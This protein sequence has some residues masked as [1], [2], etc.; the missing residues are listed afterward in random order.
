ML[1]KLG[2]F[3]SSNGLVK[4]YD[5]E[6]VDCERIYNASLC[7][8]TNKVKI[9]LNIIANKCIAEVEIMAYV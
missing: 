4:K 1:K 8:L 6:I 2:D 7:S 5:N 9:I 3:F